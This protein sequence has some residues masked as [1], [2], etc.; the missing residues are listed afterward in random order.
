MM[1]TDHTWAKRNLADTRT[2]SMSVFGLTIQPTK[3]QVISA[4]IGIITEFEMKS[5]KSRMLDPSPIGCTN[6]SEL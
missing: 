3:M 2:S 1:T 5:R 4:E 6:E